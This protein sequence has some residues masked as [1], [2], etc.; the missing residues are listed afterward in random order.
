MAALKV[1]TG[2]GDG[3]AGTGVLFHCNVLH[4]SGHNPLADDR[5]HIDV[6]YN[7]VANKP[8]LALNTRPDWVVSRNWCPVPI[9]D[10]EGVTKAA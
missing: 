4:E 9:E 3:R 6:S 2:R 7:A 8:M 1:P 10:D 5:W